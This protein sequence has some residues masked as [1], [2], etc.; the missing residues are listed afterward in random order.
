M[1]KFQL[2]TATFAVITISNS[3]AQ[4]EYNNYF[5]MQTYWLRI[6]PIYNQPNNTIE[7]IKVNYKRPNKEKGSTNIA[8]YNNLGKLVELSSLNKKGIEIPGIQ[9]TYDKNGNEMSVTRFK[10]GKIKISTTFQRMED[11][12]MLSYETINKTGKIIRKGT[13]TYNENK[14]L[15]ESSLYKKGGK[16]IKNRWV[17]EYYDKCKRSKTTL[18]KGNGKIINSWSYDCKAEGEKLT[19]KK[20]ETQVCHW[21]QSSV[22]FLTYV[23]QTF[24]EKGKIVKY[25]TKYTAIDTLPVEHYQYDKNDELRSKD[26]YDKSFKKPLHRY[27][28]KKGK[29]FIESKYTYMDS[30]QTSYEWIKKGV[31]QSKYEFSYN[32]KNLLSTQK[33]YGKKGKLN[34]IVTLTYTLKH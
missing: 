11:G 6:D 22:D 30:L 19:A 12:Q 2:L 34:S 14:C 29:L 4:Q 7:K 33:W 32:E 9:K 1:N 20:N 23:Y 31:V 28:Y 21:E 25:V 27:Y 3:I 16:K 26:T 8:T 24:D 10:K 18:Y 17:Y 5:D 15:I 13:W